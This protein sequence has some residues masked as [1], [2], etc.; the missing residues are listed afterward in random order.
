MTLSLGGCWTGDNFYAASESEAAVPAG[1]YRIVDYGGP[2][3]NADNADF[4]KFIKISYNKD[5][6]ASV[7]AE[8]A[9]DTSEARLFK[10][11]PNPGLY[12]VQADLGAPLLSVGSSLYALVN[13]I[14]GGYQ[15][16]VPRCDQKRA[17]IWDRAITSGI[18]VGKP[19]CKFSNRT[20]FEAA[21]LDYA[22]DPITWTE[23]Q[24][25]EKRSKKRG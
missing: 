10:L 13:V 9:G 3:S 17:S 19:V 14:P 5:G 4:G 2:V 12:V 1:K 15:I 16:A 20:D 21:M 18:L 6:L 11:G 23:Y 7:D 24:R 25:V 22:K 8:D